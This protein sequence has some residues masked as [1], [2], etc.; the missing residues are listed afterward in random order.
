M[1]STARLVFVAALFGAVHA[2]TSATSSNIHNRALARVIT[3]CSEDNTVAI[4]FDDGPH[5]W[6]TNL[7][8]LLNENDAKGT[9][10]FNGDNYGCIYDDDNARRVKYVYDQGHQVASHTWAHKDLTELSDGD[11]RSEFSRTNNAIRKITGAFPAFMRPPYGNYNDHVRQVAA[12]NG[13]KVVIWD[14]DSED[15]IGATP[16]KSKQMYK[17]LIDS[18]PNTILA[19]NHETYETTVDD[20]IPYAIGQIKAKG[21]RMVT[22]AECI[23]D[24]PYKSTGNPSRRDSSW[25]C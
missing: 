8:D 14:F 21:Y 15:S 23:G 5:Y 4:T 3:E 18:Q 24:S 11:L 16:A 17:D 10:F 7:V 6:T 19:L 22:L 9:F 12:D 20:V 1:P 25:K 13:Q 2:S